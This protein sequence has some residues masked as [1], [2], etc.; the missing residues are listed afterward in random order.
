MNVE[1]TRP[2]AVVTGA[3]KGIGFHLAREF[4]LHG[5]DL[6]IASD[7]DDIETAAR[8][9][10]AEHPGCGV[11]ALN[12]DL[13]TSD[14]VTALWQAISA[15]GV[16][17]AAIAVNAGVGVGG[18]F[19]ETPLDDELGMIH[20]NCT[21]AVHLTKLAVQQM[22]RRG[23]GKILITSSIAAVM[24]A[25]FEAVYGATKAF[26]MSFAEALHNELKERG[27]TVTA[28]MPG[29]TDTNF[30][31]RA[32]MEDTKVGRSEKDDPAEVAKDG[33][34][35]LMAGE[36]Q[37][38]AGSFKNKLMAGATKLMSQQAAANQ[39]RKMTEPGSGRR[40]A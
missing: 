11:A 15:R 36:P 16:P 9:I 38:V 39:H 34:A 30:F 25:P 28:L 23:E 40:D 10:E 19:E 33:F 22:V 29:A 13:A 26:L 2:L 3:S 7:H 18:R 4:A 32:G 12:V 24:P 20:L 35:A 5:Y 1:T 6:L 27:V 14:G 17:L 21:G 37:V 31:R 8:S